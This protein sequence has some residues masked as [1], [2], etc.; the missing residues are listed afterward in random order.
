MLTPQWY[1]HWYLLA[2]AVLLLSLLAALLRVAIGP[3]RPDRMLGAQ[4]FGTTGVAIVLLLAYSDASD[5][6]GAS[7][8]GAILDVALVMAVLA[9][10][11]VVAFVRRIWAPAEGEE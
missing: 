5:A 10:V 9:V 6:S 3:T 11:A 2:A 4:M 1:L 8:D 7:E